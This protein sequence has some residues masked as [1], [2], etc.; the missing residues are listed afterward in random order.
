MIEDD[1]RPV[2]PVGVF[3]VAWSRDTGMVRDFNEDAACVVAGCLAA[4]ES[5]SAFGLLTVVDGS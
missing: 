4:E 3:S 2:Q 1:V 5:A